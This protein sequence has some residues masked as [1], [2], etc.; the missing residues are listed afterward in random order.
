MPFFCWLVFLC[1][2]TLAKTPTCDFPVSSCVYRIASIATLEEV[3]IFLV[4]K[5]LLLWSTMSWNYESREE[6]IDW[7]YLFWFYSIYLFIYSSD[8]LDSDLQI[9]RI[10]S[11]Q[12]RKCLKVN[13]SLMGRSFLQS[14]LIQ[15]RITLVDFGTWRICLVSFPLLIYPITIVSFRESCNDVAAKLAQ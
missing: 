9:F 2:V 15:R 1:G 12:C 10:P 13:N 11:E 14:F 3:I 5:M 8:W 4:V 7:F 6:E